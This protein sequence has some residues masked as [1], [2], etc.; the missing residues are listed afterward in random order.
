MGM[1]RP[2]LGRVVDG[3]AS[4]TWK[5]ATPEAI[6]E[7]AEIC[8]GR[9][10]GPEA[11]TVLHWSKG[12]EYVEFTTTKGADA[13]RLIKRCGSAITHYYVNDESVSLRIPFRNS[14]GKKIFRGFELAFGSIDIESTPWQGPTSN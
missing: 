4:M 1:G 12:D 8:K 11:E 2:F 6:A 5:P 13:G 3:E 7:L 14:E 9:G 10:G